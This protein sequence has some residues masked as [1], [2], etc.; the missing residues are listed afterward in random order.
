VE[1]CSGSFVIFQQNQVSIFAA[2]ND[3]YRKTV[4]Q[5]SSRRYATSVNTETS[6]ELSSLQQN[7]I[8]NN[9][10]NNNTQD[11]IYSA[12]SSTARSHMREFTWG[13]LSGSRSAS[14]GLQLVGRAATWPLSLLLGSYMPNIHPSPYVLLLNHN[15]DTH[16]PSHGDGRLSGQRHCSMCVARA[17]SRVSQ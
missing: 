10:I 13:P 8:R 15:D 4:A 7:D 11:H 12:I 5:V 9:N 17:Q 6:A 16:L 2:I 3:I 1:A 14:G